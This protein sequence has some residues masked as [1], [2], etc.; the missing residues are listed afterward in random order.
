MKRLQGPVTL[1]PKQCSKKTKISTCQQQVRLPTTQLDSSQE[2]PLVNREMMEL[3]ARSKE[4]MRVVLF[5]LLD[6]SKME[7]SVKFQ[8]TVKELVLAA[9][10]LPRNQEKLLYQ[11]NRSASQLETMLRPAFLSQLL[12]AS[13]LL[14][15]MLEK[16]IQSMLAQLPQLQK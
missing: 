4:K 5:H 10:T 7:L 9:A 14:T 13:L 15:L 12:K 1:R 16:A 8:L 2:Q 6:Q 3:F 11:L